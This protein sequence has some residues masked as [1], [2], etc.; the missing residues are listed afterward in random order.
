V[1]SYCKDDK[2]V[3]VSVRDEG[4]GIAEADQERIFEPF[5]TTKLDGEGTGL[6]LCIVRNIVETNSGVLTLHSDLGAGA[7]FRCV[8]PVF[9]DGA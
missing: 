9:S 6:G 1:T 3:I 7:E 8:M 5:F 2:Q 4:P